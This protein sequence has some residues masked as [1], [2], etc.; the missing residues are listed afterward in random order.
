MWLNKA[1][2]SFI[3]FQS[4]SGS[5]KLSGFRLV[6]ECDFFADVVSRWVQLVSFVCKSIFFDLFEVKI[7]LNKVFR[8]F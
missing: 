7:R 1:F 8:F 3:F 6:R 5:E 2:R 4:V